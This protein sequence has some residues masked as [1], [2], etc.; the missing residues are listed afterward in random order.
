MLR[1]SE[2]S[3]FLEINNIIRNLQNELTLFLILHYAP[4][5][6]NNFHMHTRLI[7]LTIHLIIAFNLTP[8]SPS[9]IKDKLY[10]YS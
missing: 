10:P 7:S 4:T 6:L 3:K 8:T 5:D 2:L 1:E 9:N